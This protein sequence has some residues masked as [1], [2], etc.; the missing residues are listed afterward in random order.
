MTNVLRHANA[1]RV[2]IGLDVRG[3]NILLRV[4]DDGAGIDRRA[5]QSPESLGLR[6][7]RERA[8]LS[9]GRLFLGPLR[10]SGT[11]VSVRVPIE[12]LADWCNT[13]NDADLQAS[14]FNAR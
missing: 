13:N 7:M 2:L 5:V 8:A 6:G 9:R 10:P 3:R 11:L 4:C 1:S 12:N 14:R